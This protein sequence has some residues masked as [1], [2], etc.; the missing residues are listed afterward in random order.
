MF[1]H[2]VSAY[3]G[4]PAEVSVLKEELR[5]HTDVY[6]RRVSKFVLL[7][8]IGANACM[9]GRQ[10][11]RDTA[12]YLTTENGNLADTDTVLSQLYRRHALPLP[13]NF[14]NTM[15]NTASFYIA[16]GLGLFGRNLS[17]SSQNLSFERGLELL[18]TDMDMGYVRRALI[19]L[20]DQAASSSFHFEDSPDGDGA[21]VNQIDRS[22]WL[23]VTSE[24]EGAIG[25]VAGIRSFKSQDD[26]LAWLENIT[27]ALAPD[28]AIAFG[29]AVGRVEK[30]LWSARIQAAW[31]RPAAVFNYIKNF[32]SLNVTT[33][34][35]VARFL[36]TSD[37]P[38]LLHINRNFNDQYVILH[39]I[40]YGDASPI[41]SKTP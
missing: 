35:G 1:I 3:V 31:S 9:A 4:G 15:A 25:D 41:L 2:D 12:V 16:Q 5:R 39:I 10:P 21:L 30:D 24:K 34:C 17:I 18:K 32:G 19:G 23:Y 40:K 20:V 13:F 11:D 38:A 33:A 7:A 14:I 36:K 8:L 6:F 29:A 22:C 26:A 37:A 28:T 27:E